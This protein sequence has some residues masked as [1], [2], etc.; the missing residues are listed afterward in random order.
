MHFIVHVCVCSS[1]VA[2]FAQTEYEAKP[3]MQMILG[4]KRLRLLLPRESTG[5]PRRKFNF[6]LLNWNTSGGRITS[7]IIKAHDTWIVSVEGI[8]AA[9]RTQINSARVI[10]KLRRHNK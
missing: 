10:I 7:I 5:P 9:V 1:C 3:L 8:I 2:L 6:D 4:L